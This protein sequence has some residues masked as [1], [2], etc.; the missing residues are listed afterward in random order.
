[1]KEFNILRRG[2]KYFTA[3]T[4]AYTC[5]ILIDAASENL[6]LGPQTL[7]VD[8]ISVRSKYGTD[9]IFKLKTSAKE[10]EQ[11][12][13]CTLRH[14]RYNHD[15]VERCREL[16]GL[17][18]RDAKAWVFSAL[19]EDQVELLDIYWNNDIVH[20]QITLPNGLT[21]RCQAVTIG[22]YTIATASG[23]DSG[24]TVAQGVA[25][26]S[27]DVDSGGSRVNWETEIAEGSV[28]RLR[29]PKALIADLA[30]YQDY[31]IEILD[32]E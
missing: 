11:A 32:E 1:M 16:D 24:A 25:L 22:G 15:L 4:G 9:L 8:D 3:T 14:F 23:R 2:R 30:Q 13:I 31:Q 17:W 29:M 12:G 10:Q 6:D 28:L 5:K 18:D 7:D 21:A 20:V 19:V 26:I 27:G